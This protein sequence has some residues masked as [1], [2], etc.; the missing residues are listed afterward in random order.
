MGIRSW[1]RIR[2]RIGVSSSLFWASIMN[3]TW[4]GRSRGALGSSV[5]RGGANTSA[6]VNALKRSNALNQNASQY[7]KNDISYLILS[8]KAK[9]KL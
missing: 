2:C 4:L 7:L 8:E 1:R 3:S 5:I 9:N 6:G